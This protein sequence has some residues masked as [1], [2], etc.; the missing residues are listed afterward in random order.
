MPLGSACLKNESP[1]S[2]VC[3]GGKILW[4]RP[5]ANVRKN[6][7]PRKRNKTAK[8]RAKKKL[9]VTR[10]KAASSHGKRGGRTR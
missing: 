9:R 4:S 3:R 8:Y 7:P 10:R 5:M 1:A 6:R 2:A